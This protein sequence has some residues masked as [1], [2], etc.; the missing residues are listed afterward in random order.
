M[1]E[2]E[3]TDVKFIVGK[4]SQENW[5]ILDTYKSINN[6]YVWFHLIKD[7]LVLYSVLFTG[8]PIKDKDKAYDG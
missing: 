5:Q 6:K 8:S 3:F 2:Y 4:N 7:D 1:K